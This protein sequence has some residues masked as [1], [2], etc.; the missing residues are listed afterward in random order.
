M[1][2]LLLTKVPLREESFEHQL[3]QLGHEVYCSTSMITVIRNQSYSEDFLYQFEAII[4]SETLYDKE[5]EELIALLPQGNFK[6]FRRS[7]E[8]S[9]QESDAWI[10]VEASLERLREVLLA[11][12]ISRLALK[13]V[14]RTQQIAVKQQLSELNLKLKQKEIVYYLIKSGDRTVSRTEISR[15]IWGKEPTKSI[16]ASL[17]KVVSKINEKLEIELGEEAIQTIWGQGYRLNKRVFDF[18]EKEI[19]LQ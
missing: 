10:P 6:V 3:K 16:L 5:A 8:T 2:L 18:L 19:S 15:Q 11:A 9:C 12:E 13:D 4:F 14:E 17:S 1:Q 7:S